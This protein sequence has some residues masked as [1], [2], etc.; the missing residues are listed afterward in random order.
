MAEPDFAIY[1]TSLMAGLLAG[2]LARDHGRSVVRVGRRPSAQ[3]LPRALPLALPLATRPQS[4]RLIRAAESEIAA[5]LGSAGVGESLGFTEAALFADLPGTTGAID[6]LAHVALGYGHQL[7]RLPGG[8]SFRRVPLIDREQ[9]EAR[10]PDWLRAAGVV[11]HEEGPVAARRIVL[12]DDSSILEQLPEAQ[13]PAGLR[14]QAMT[15]TLLAAPR[16][17]DIPVQRF[18][19]RGVF[20]ARH[21]PGTVLALVAGGGEVEERLASALPPPFPVR[22]LATTRY[23]R[24]VS[25]DGAPVI[26]APADGPFIATGLGSCA[27]FLAP[28][29]ARHL[30]GTAGEAEAAWFAAHAPDAARSAI[31]DIAAL[32]ELAP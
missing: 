21:T 16:G 29:L 5:V 18:A 12:A 3:R 28:G 23:R 14:V 4:W 9:V 32:A 7:R 2:L 20:L 25:L 1:G 19:D 8:W 17:F 24:L 26:G 22:R 31:A 11:L 15:A 30:A 27:A 10:M 6:H 13:R